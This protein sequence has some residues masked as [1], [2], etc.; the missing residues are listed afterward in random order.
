MAISK[1]DLGAQ[2]TADLNRAFNEE[3]GKR[4]F[5][6]GHEMDSYNMA[7]AKGERQ[8]RS[9]YDVNTD[10][11]RTTYGGSGIESWHARGAEHH[12]VQQLEGRLQKMEREHKQEMR[13]LVSQVISMNNALDARVQHINGFYTWL[14]ET[15]PETVAQYKALLD[16]KRLTEGEE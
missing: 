13:N 6:S 15:Y 10:S 11:Y 8:P 9:I 5:A 16:L 12:L 7:I 2:L 1:K 4:Q 3:Y 14:I